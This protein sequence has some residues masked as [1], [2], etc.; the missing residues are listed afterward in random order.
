MRLVAVGAAVGP[1]SRVFFYRTEKLVH[2]HR[3]S[4]YDD[5]ASKCQAHLHGG[6]R[7]NEEVADALVGSRH[8]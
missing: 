5:Q 7:R 6:S 2:Y 4:T 3:H 1:A 8:F